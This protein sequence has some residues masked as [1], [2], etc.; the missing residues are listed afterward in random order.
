MFE[1]MCRHSPNIFENRMLRKVYNIGSDEGRGLLGYYVKSNVIIDTG[2][3]SVVR[4]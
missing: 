1:H 2:A 3:Q 4:W